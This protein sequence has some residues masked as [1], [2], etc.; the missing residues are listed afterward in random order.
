MINNIYPNFLR[1]EVEYGLAEDFWIKIWES[2]DVRDRMRYD[3]RHPWF[4]PLP[5][6]IA[7][8]N[9]I[10]SAFSPK[11]KRG[12]RIIQDEPKDSGLSIFAYPDFFG[13]DFSDPRSI[14]ELVISLVLSDISAKLA[15]ALIEPWIRGDS[16]TFRLDGGGSIVR[17]TLSLRADDAESDEMQDM[18]LAS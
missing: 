1:D 7:E 18:A 9:P 17:P 11:L 12:I 10:F 16:I 4:E 5:A 2:T 8:G 14:R 13:G 15:L 6:A 3:W